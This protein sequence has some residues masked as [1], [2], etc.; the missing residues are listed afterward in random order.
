MEKELLEAVLGTYSK[1]LE[2]LEEIKKY[3][4]DKKIEASPENNHSAEIFDKIALFSTE[5]VNKCDEKDYIEEILNTCDNKTENTTKKISEKNI[6]DNKMIKLSENKL[7]NHTKNLFENKVPNESLKNN[8]DLNELNI[9]ISN[10]NDCK[11]CSNTNTTNFNAVSIV[12]PIEES[13]IKD[14]ITDS[15]KNTEKDINDNCYGV[16]IIKLP[17]VKNKTQVL[18][19]QQNSTIKKIK[20]AVSPQISSTQTSKGIKRS[21]SPQISSTQTSKG[22]KRSVSPQIS[23]TQT[24]E[25]IKRSVSPQISSTQ[26]SK[27]IKRSVSPQISSTQTSKRI[28]ANVS[29]QISSTQIAIRP[30]LRN[31]RNQRMDNPFLESNYINFNFIGKKENIVIYS[32]EEKSEFFE[33]LENKIN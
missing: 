13:R 5:N 6:V 9:E 18:S 14:I 1:L 29:P 20:V 33:I 11:E 12:T 3:L 28:K 16:K 31:K 22:I 25:G 15:K 26:T 7:G 21:V 27:G 10:V 24:S 23:S 17:L 19:S 30:C 2:E 4:F 8:K 32:L